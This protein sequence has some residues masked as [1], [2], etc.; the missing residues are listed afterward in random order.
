MGVTQAIELSMIMAGGACLQAFFDA[1]FRSDG[2]DALAGGYFFSKVDKW[3]FARAA[4]P[5]ASSR[6]SR[7]FSALKNPMVTCCWTN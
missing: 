6:I 4:R 3:H 1:R 2:K 7:V 5:L